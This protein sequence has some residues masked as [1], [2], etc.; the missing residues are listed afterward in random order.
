MTR[1]RKSS[2]TTRT[3]AG[4]VTDAVFEHELEVF[5]TEAESALQF[6]YAYLAIHAAAGV[7]TS[8]RGRLNTAPLFWNTTLGALQTAAFVALGRLFDND[9]AHNLGT[10]LRM[11]RDNPHL[12]SKA[13]LAN[14]KQGAAAQPP[15]W[16]NDYLKQAYIP[17]A[18][19]FRR[20]QGYASRQ[21]KIYLE[22][23]QPLR[24][25]VFAHKGLSDR[26]QV[27]AL[28]A[29]TNIREL[30]RMLIFLVSLHDALW[31]LFTNGN[32][33]TLRARTLSVNRM[34]A[35][36]APAG[37]SSELHVRLVQEAQRYLST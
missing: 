25:R 6:F 16:L 35:T 32:K 2:R 30:Q 23:Y 15:A 12:F 8:V 5:R 10:L 9:S 27:T 33:P 29:K 17:T 34:L 31:Q 7:S 1:R 14:R 4:T 11:A 3:P 37:R 18:A 28:F 20:L 13:S 26:S 22:K 36:S 19:D 21:K 24:N